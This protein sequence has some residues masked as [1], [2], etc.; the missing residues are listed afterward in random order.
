MTFDNSQGRINKSYVFYLDNRC[1]L[2]QTFVKNIDYSVQNV[3]LYY[4][5]NINAYEWKP[6]NNTHVEAMKQ[7][8]M[9]F[10]FLWKILDELVQK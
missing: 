5:M 10:I 1:V 4:S 7:N 9:F 2:I 8:A 3:K 6:T